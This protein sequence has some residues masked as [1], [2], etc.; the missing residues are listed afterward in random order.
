MK[1]EQ[2]RDQWSAP[3][4][5]EVESIV[6]EQA[7]LPI[8]EG[9]VKDLMTTI[10]RGDVSALP[11]V[12]LWRKLPSSN[13]TLV[14]GRNRLEAHKRSGRK[15]IAARVRSDVMMPSVWDARS[16]FAI[17]SIRFVGRCHWSLPI[18]FMTAVTI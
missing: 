5:V 18:S 4:Y 17:R 6:V 7:R 13:P 3:E 2:E 8:D 9:V 10:D 16:R 12:H 11:P 14:A 1:P 15:A